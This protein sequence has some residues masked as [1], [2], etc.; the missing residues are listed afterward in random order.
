MADTYRLRVVKLMENPK[1]REES[2]YASQVAQE[3]FHE[4]EALSIDVT[5]AQFQAIRKAALE[6]F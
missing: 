1:Y 4:R 6:V 3:S 2:R 5:E